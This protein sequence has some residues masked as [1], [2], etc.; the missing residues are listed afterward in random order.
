ML[1][2]T[3][4]MNERIFIGDNIQITVVAIRGN[5]VRLGIEAPPEIVVLRDELRRH[6]APVDRR[7][8]VAAGD[9]DPGAGKAGLEPITT[10]VGSGL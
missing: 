8:T 2:L 3:R 9:P 4:K 1:V 6:V 10:A 7:E 5:H